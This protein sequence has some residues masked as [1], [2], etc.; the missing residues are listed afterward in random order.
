[1]SITLIT[2]ERQRRN[3][4]VYDLEWV[5]GTLRV[6]MVGVYDKEEG[7]RSY[8]TVEDFLNNEMSQKNRGKWF[9]AHAGG[10]ADVQFVLEA[11]LDEKRCKY[12]VQAAFSGSS[13]IIVTVRK[14]RHVWKFVDSY[15]LL[16]APLKD[17]GKS[18][19]M[20]KGEGVA[21]WDQ[22]TD[23]ER[24]NWYATAPIA[25][26]RDY[27]EQDCRILWHAIAAF[28]TAIWDWGGVLK[29]TQASSALELFRRRFLQRDI[30]TY[31][32]LNIYAR[33][34]YFASRVEVL[35][36]DCQDAYYYDINSSFPYSM[37]KPCPGNYLGAARRLP[38]KGLYL[39][40]VEFEVS[41]TYFPPVPARVKNRVFFPTGRWRS[42]LSNVDVELM[43]EQ[44]NKLKKVYEVHRFDEFTD[45]AEYVNTI[46]DHRKKATDE[47]TRTVDKLLLNSLYGKFGESSTKIS[48]HYNPSERLLKSWQATEADIEELFPGCWL[49]YR[50]SE[51]SH[52]HVAIS[53]HITALSRKNIFNFMAQC[54]DMHY[55]DTDGF[56]TSEYL[57]AG[58]KELG[59]LKLERP[60]GNARWIAP[61]VYQMDEKVKAKGFSLSKEE[62]ESHRQFERLVENG[63]ISVTRMTRLRELYKSQKT[64]PEETLIV[65]GLTSIMNGK[66]VHKRHM[67]P[68]GESRPWHIEELRETL[69]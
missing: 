3:F 43:Q 69:L 15:W 45:L 48:M 20:D 9:Y 11:L 50:E 28:E 10:L 55:V 6:R 65:K 59:D 51:V 21:G 23:S 63:R 27:N 61:K 31:E 41:D 2:S 24:K 7:Y 42:W 46:Y 62:G 29:M 47:F 32:S 53:V 66:A 16:R 18:I 60:I 40:D 14:D 19:G 36:A 30:D 57:G 38:D 56:S 13:A 67:Y 68:D 26:L 22:F 25:E 35:A 1:M 54:R 58:T 64:R 5:P 39:A 17:I 37:T 12:N 34:A 44:G 52:A 33:Q 8:S 4:L 49:E